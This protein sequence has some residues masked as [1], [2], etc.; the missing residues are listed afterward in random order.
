MTEQ[1][2]QLNYLRMA[3][4]KVRL[5]PNLIKG[6]PV[7]SAEA[8]LILISKRSALPLL[9]LIRSAVSSIKEKNK[10]I[11]SDSLFIKKIIVNEGPKLKRFLP[12][13]RGSA[14]SIQKK[15]SHISLVID[16]IKDKNFKAKFNI[17]RKKKEKKEEK[18]GKKPELKRESSKKIAEKEVEKPGRKEVAKEKGFFK[19]MFRRKSV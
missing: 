7:N 17:I 15:S 13:A 10:N 3:P 5:I 19:Q 14:S 18:S 6:M 4:R 1:K 12:R 9:K 8:E 2:V 16:E 11:N